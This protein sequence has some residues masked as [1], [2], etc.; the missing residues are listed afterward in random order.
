MARAE[1]R[2]QQL[3]G[4]PRRIAA[5]KKA[6]V[7]GGAGFIGNALCAKLKSE[8][9]WV[10]AVDIRS[11][12]FG[13]TDCDDFAYYDLRTGMPLW[14]A[15]PYGEH[16]F[17]EVYQFA[18][19]MGGAG[20]LFTGEHDAEI[21]T[22]NVRINANVAQTLS[23]TGCGRLLYTSSA[24]VYND[25]MANKLVGPLLESDANNYLPSNVYGSEKRFSEDLY[26]A[27]ERN[28]GLNVCITR[29]STIYGPGSAFD[30]GRENAVAAICRKVI[31][32]PQ[33]GDVEVWGDGK[34]IRPLV[35]IDDLLGGITRLARSSASR[36]PMNIASDELTTCDTIAKLAI[37]RSNKRLT[38]K[39][40]PGPVGKQQLVM[41]T[42]LAACTLGWKA[43][44]PFSVGL[45]RTFDWIASQK[46][47]K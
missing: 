30:G 43:S 42:K 16:R 15:Y 1:Y 14:L 11:S 41:S 37:A 27:H 26:I 34:Q 4:D 32:A 21:I 13:D 39:Y 2:S 45:E 20:Y 24:C 33:D 40:V 12:P 9:Y 23:R 7:L 44:T 29:F 3:G 35:Y 36:G 25:V 28:Y 31:D 17:D 46:A 10:R 8:G 47:Q 22:D 18:A 5:M 38:I 19:N 6:L